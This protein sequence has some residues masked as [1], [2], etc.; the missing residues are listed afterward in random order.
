MVAGQSSLAVNREK[1]FV[2]L[3]LLGTLGM[4][5]SPMLLIEGILYGLLA[6]EANRNNQVVGV[7]EIIYL[8]GWAC[9]MIGMHRLRALGES[10]PGKVVFVVQLT[11]LMLAAAFAVGDI[12]SPNRDQGTLLFRVTDAAW[13]LSHLFML[14][15]G[16]FLIYAGAWR[17]WRRFA[18][19]L[20]GLAL[21][22]FFAM[23]ALVGREAGGLL[24][25]IATMSAFML[26][27]QA[28]RTAHGPDEAI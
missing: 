27:G 5:G 9:S 21:P 23:G 12:V 26:L 3:R 4:I 8:G 1:A 14:V 28:V 24:F 6:A 18:P 22:L 20:C 11:G 10:L 16:G 2:S 7:L 19:L 17:G 13:P 25:G 15:L